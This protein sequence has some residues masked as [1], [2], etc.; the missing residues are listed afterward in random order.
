MQ[1]EL[2]AIAWVAAEQKAALL[3][4]RDFDVRGWVDVLSV[5]F[6]VRVGRL[7]G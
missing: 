1:E 5:R 2:E 6:E 4:V 3:E 7:G